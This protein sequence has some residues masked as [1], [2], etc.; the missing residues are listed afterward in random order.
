MS[1]KAKAAEDRFRRS[2]LHVRSKTRDVRATD[3]LPADTDVETGPIGLTR[4]ARATDSIGTLLTERK[5]VRHA[6]FIATNPLQRKTAR[7]N[8]KSISSAGR[9][10]KKARG[11]TLRRME[12]PKRDRPE[13]GCPGQRERSQ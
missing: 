5:R 11:P 13:A 10:E 8:A 1:R 3:R 4:A 6:S 9:F 12:T 2:H 7:A